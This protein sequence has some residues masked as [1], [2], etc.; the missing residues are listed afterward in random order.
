MNL[1]PLYRLY[2]E[3]LAQNVKKKG[4]K[5]G[6]RGG[7]GK[8]REKGREEGRKKWRQRDEKKEMLINKCIP[9]SCIIVRI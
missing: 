9:F 6:R 3:P 8:G 1:R 2:S 4:R 5:E 7:K